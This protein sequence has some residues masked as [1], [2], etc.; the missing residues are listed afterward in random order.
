MR[1]E[2][3]MA[4]P[5]IPHRPPATGPGV[6]QASIVVPLLVQ[7]DAWLRQCLL[8]ALHQSVPTEVIVVTSPRTT[9][10]NIRILADLERRYH[11]LRI[12]REPPRS[13]FAGAI[14]AGIDY[15]ST[16]RVGLLLSDDWLDATA[17]EECLQRS[18]DIV[19][20]GARIY[21]A[22][23]I[24]RLA[25]LPMIMSQFEAQPTLEAKADYLKHFFL[26][27]RAR[28][29]EVGGVDETVGLTGPDDYDMV[30]TLLEH[31]ATAGVTERPL[32]NYRDHFGDRLTLR[33]RSEQV[34]DLGKI[35]DKHGVHGEERTRVIERHSAWYGLPW[36]VASRRLQAGAHGRPR[37][38]D[39]DP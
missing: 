8:S 18:T 5:P 13:G 12:L 3:V 15:A 19:S 32:Y 10:S 21:A 11:H 31:G 26:F 27:V 4:D 2:V 17:V 37:L 34:L 23:G 25:E 38:D 1:D 29:V 28:L 14:N 22:D 7:R 20:T 9:A 30:W 39:S 16:G 36:H 24:T 35:L 6:Y 33:A